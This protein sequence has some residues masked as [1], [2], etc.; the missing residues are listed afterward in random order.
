MRCSRVLGAPILRVA[1][2]EAM[3]ALTVGVVLEEEDELERCRAIWFVREEI[4]CVLL[5]GANVAAN[6]NENTGRLWDK[7]VES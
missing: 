1:Y 5:G 7:A 2:W 4:L 3:F 6:E